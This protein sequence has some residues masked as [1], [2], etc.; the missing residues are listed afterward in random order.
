MEHESAR[1]IIESIAGDLEAT[2]V[3]MRRAMAQIDE[4]RE[5]Q[6]TLDLLGTTLREH[7]KLDWLLRSHLGE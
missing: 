2:I 5:D 3:A 6:G 1:Q 4:A 7:E